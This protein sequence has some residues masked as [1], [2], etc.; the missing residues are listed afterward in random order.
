MNRPV[1][2]I[3]LIPLL[4]CAPAAQRPTG[5]AETAHQGEAAVTSIEERL[6]RY[7]P[8]ELAADLAGVPEGEREVL[9][10][11]IAAGRL[12]DEIFLRQVFAG[13]PDLRDQV[14]SE[15]EALRTYFAV[16][17]GP[18]DRLDEMQPYLGE[19]AHPE[20]AGY[21]PVAG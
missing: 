7:A 2:I 17:F 20:G 12:M 4:A 6:G 19:M 5:D 13:N 9:K 14:A 11:L 18:W 8:T 10:E 15:S 21:Y 1:A 16:N 3:G